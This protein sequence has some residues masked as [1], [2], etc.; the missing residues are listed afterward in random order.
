MKLKFS[1]KAAQ[2]VAKYISENEWSHKFQV[3]IVAQKY[4]WLRSMIGSEVWLAQKYDFHLK[5]ILLDFKKVQ[6]DTVRILTL[7]THYWKHDAQIIK[8]CS[9]KMITF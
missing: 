8:F 9:F 5:I 6:Y 1:E 3:E 4:D 2:S 7:L